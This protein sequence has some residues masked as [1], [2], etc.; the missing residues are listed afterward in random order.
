VENRII[1]IEV[2]YQLG[3]AAFFGVRGCGIVELGDW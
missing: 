2:S 1:Q 3:V